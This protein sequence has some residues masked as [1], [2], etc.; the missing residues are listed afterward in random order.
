MCAAINDE[1]SSDTE[2]LLGSQLTGREFG[3][4][5]FTDGPIKPDIHFTSSG[6]SDS[7]VS[8]DRPTTL[9]RSSETLVSITSGSKPPSEKSNISLTPPAHAAKHHGSHLYTT[10]KLVLGLLIVVAIALSWVGSTQMAKSSFT[11][12]QFEAPF[13]VMWFGTAWMMC[14]Y[15]LSCVLFFVLHRNQWSWTGVKI[16]WR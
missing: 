16:L 15:P 14:V 12:S 4:S 6:I 3:G 13:F 1:D 2:S 10:K 11:P 5:V 8:R 9:M 7:T